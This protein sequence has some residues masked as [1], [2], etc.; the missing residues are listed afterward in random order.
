MIMNKKRRSILL[1]TAGLTLSAP[2]MAKTLLST[3]R[4]TAGPF[5]PVELPLDDDND[6]TTVK[7]LSGKASGEITDLTGTIK[8]INGQPISDLRIEIW[9]CDANG[10]YRHPR[11]RGEQPVDRF[12]QGHGSTRTDANGL[13]RFRT[14]RPVPYPGRT[15]H[16]HVAVFPRGERPF[17][18]QLYVKND[19]R[20]AE[21]F[22]FN[23]IPS[24]RR[25]LVLSEFVPSS[26][27]ETDLNAAFD[28]ILNRHNGT[29]MG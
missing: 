23:H 26:A 10:R 28:I 20:N 8:D 16:I 6:L 21:D 3:P 27:S 11:E 9:Q 1:A 7:G 4:Q 25:H 29:P 5:Y 24:D 13:Y 14:I 18:T 22:V 15:P 2:L 19:S 17:V 12:F